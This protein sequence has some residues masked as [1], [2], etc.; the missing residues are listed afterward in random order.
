MSEAGIPQLPDS[1]P[2]FGG[3]SL[4]EVKLI[5]ELLTYHQY[6]DGD[7]I[8]SEGEIGSEM[9]IIA[10]GACQV[11][12]SMGDAQEPFVLAECG[13]GE[14]LGEMALIEIKPRSATLRAIGE[15][16]VF[17]LVNGDFLRLYE[18]NLHTYTMVLLNVSRE[19]SRRLRRSNRVLATCAKVLR[20]G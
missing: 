7:L 11:S 5:Q 12:K 8:A 4:D 15:V 9:F 16:G 18:T 14:V 20:D 13:V 17:T 2:I 3:L 6:D 19:L 10:K 1:I